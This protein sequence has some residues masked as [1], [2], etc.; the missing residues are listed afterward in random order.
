MS[1]EGACPGEGPFA[2]NLPRLSAQLARSL[3]REPG[4]RVNWFAVPAASTNTA[5]TCSIADRL[6]SDRLDHG[7]LGTARTLVDYV[8]AQIEALEARDSALTHICNRV[9]GG[10]FRVLVI[11]ANERREQ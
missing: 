7:R 4:P 6:R 3:D 11:E 10:G 2:A 5:L 1:R 9:R 8:I